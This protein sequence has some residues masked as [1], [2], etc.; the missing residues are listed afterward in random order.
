MSYEHK[1]KLIDEL[2]KVANEASELASVAITDGTDYFI[3]S[4]ESFCL[5]DRL[6]SLSSILGGNLFLYE[7]RHDVLTDSSVYA[8]MCGSELVYVGQT[9]NTYNRIREH[10][11]KYR[12]DCIGVIYLPMDRLL[13]AE[14][15]AI[16]L[17]KPIGNFLCDKKYAAFASQN[18]D[19]VIRGR[20][21]D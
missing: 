12:W 8:L 21:R 10:D 18:H 6:L 7:D 19:K 15:L 13:H 14:C 20:R 5:E 3:A 4:S 9:E 16:G 2:S 11:R 1:F 17:L